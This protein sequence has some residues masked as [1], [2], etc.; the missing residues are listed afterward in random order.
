MSKLTGTPTSGRI[1]RA[2]DAGFGV[3]KF[4]RSPN[5]DERQGAAVVCDHFLSIAID[6]EKTQTPFGN[7]QQRDTV[8]VAV[9]NRSYEVGKGVRHTMVAS[10]FGR[11]MTDAYYDSTVYHALM[12]GALSYMKEEHIDTLVLGLPMNHFENKQ[13]VAKLQGQYSGKI[14]LG[15]GKTMQIDN[16]IVHPQPFGGYISLGRDI[17]GINAALKRY[18]ECGV[19]PLESPS[20]LAKL[21]VLIVDPGEYTLDWLLMT[22]SGPAQ[23]VSSAASDA[24]RHRILRDLREILQGKTDRPLGASFLIDIDEAL[25][26]KKP[27]RIAGRSY[28]LATEEFQRAI[29]KAVEDPVRQLFE[30]LRGADDRIDLVAVLGGSGKEI[31]DAIRKERPYLPVYC[32]D[33]ATG[34]AASLYANLRGFQEWA[35]AVDLRAAA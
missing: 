20:D 26:E 27:F 11:D 21:N 5:N 9:G 30:G 24:G 31:A 35:E 29:E 23:R 25:R 18:P 16:C 6:A 4:T 12:L 34:Q 15:Y 2:I 10:D 22:P 1:A 28:D 3:M 14:D 19:K 17:T 8:L 13:R 33:Q 7:S 32:P